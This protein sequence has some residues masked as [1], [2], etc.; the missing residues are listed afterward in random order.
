MKS[1][2]YEIIG[3]AMEVHR[4]LGWGLLEAVY[5]EALSIELQNRLIVHGIEVNLPI[6]YKNIKMTKTYRMDL[7]V[8]DKIIVELKSVADVLPEHRVQLFNYM[9]L[10]KKQYALLINFGEL[11]LHCERYFYDENINECYLLDKNLNRVNY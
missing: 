10:T 9:R 2:F 8:E 11:S 4:I 1:L 3:S 6:F 7:V 5:Q